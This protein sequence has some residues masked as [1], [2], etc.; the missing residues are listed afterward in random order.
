[1]IRSFHHKGLQRFYAK[2]DRKGLPP[3]LVDKISR[4]LAR[5]DVAKAPQQMDLPGLK[6]HPLK[7]ELKGFWS[8]RVTGNWR[9]VFRF[10]GTD[11]VQ[12]DL[13]DYH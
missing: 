10:E 9:I 7:G 13:M 6:L 1:M 11:V 5:L 2:D 4:I 3:A 12:V 8:V